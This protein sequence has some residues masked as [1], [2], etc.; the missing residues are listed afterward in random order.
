MYLQTLFVLSVA[1][2]YAKVIFKNQHAPPFEYIIRT[3]NTQQHCNSRTPEKSP[4][5]AFHYST[6]IR[7]NTHETCVA[8]YRTHSATRTAAGRAERVPS[9]LV[10]AHSGLIGVGSLR[11]ALHLHRSSECR[12]SALLVVV[13]VQLPHT[14]HCL[15]RPCSLFKYPTS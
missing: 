8:N 15:S 6:N 1:T 11:Y 12:C 5:T 7:A 14:P 10:F 4:Q 3:C 9:E 13:V 2:K